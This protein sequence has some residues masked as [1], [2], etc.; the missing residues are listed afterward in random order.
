MSSGAI[1][2]IGNSSIGRATAVMV[3]PPEPTARLRHRDSSRRQLPGP[4]QEIANFRV[5]AGALRSDIT[6]PI[7]SP[8]MPT[9]VVSSSPPQSTV[10]DG[11]AKAAAD[12]FLTFPFG[13]TGSSRP[14]MPP[15]P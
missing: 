12:F 4:A 8:V 3:V 14:T 6:C 9:P 10:T 1:V 2:V 7:S 11:V 15:C 13:R 5:G